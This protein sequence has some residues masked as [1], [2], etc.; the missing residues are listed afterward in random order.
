MI[1]IYAK[2]S[3]IPE[4]KYFIF[5]QPP[6]KTVKCFYTTHCK[7]MCCLWLPQYN[8]WKNGYEAIATGDFNID[9]L[10]INDKHIISEYFDKL[11][12][13]SF[14]PKITVPTRLTNN[15]GRLIDNFICKLT[16]CT[17]DTTGGVLI[18][19][20]SDHQ[21]YFIKYFWDKRHTASICI[22]T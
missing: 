18:N 14:Y 22:S 5:V 2:G 20:F 3:Q 16:E 11:T 15:N 1:I 9:V 21:P 4:E 13:Y 10:K 6:I 12:S 7:E 8:H 17:L 19:T